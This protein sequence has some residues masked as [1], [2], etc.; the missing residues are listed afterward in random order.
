[1]S[2]RLVSPFPWGIGLVLAASKLLVFPS[3]A[4][5]I[6]CSDEVWVVLL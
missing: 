3:S 1:M 6:V 4:C 2:R 5:F